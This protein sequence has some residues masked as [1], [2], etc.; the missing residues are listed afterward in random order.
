MYIT[1]FSDCLFYWLNLSPLNV[2]SR[3]FFTT[4][5]T[6]ESK[7]TK[8]KGARFA[9]AKTLTLFFSPPAATDGKN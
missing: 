5:L 4:C 3:F 1:C 6:H 7:K 8:T 2:A 9:F